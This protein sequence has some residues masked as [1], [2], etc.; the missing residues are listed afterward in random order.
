MD[1]EALRVMDIESLYGGLNNNLAEV[2]VNLSLSKMS[3]WWKG[4]TDLGKGEE[5]RW[6]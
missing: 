5:G 1:G 2:G 3:N 4:V 6:F